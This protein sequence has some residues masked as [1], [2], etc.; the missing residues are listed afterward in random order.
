[1]QNL[2][3]RLHLFNQ[4]G[5]FSRSNWKAFKRSYNVTSATMQVLLEA[6]REEFFSGAKQTLNKN[7]KIEELSLYAKQFFKVF[8][9]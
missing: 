2:K 3:P 5:E 8:L 6:P 4:N 7:R 9:K 1:L